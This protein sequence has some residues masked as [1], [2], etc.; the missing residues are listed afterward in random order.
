MKLPRQWTA[1]DLA[2]VAL[3][4]VLPVSMLL[5]GA[6][7]G[8]SIDPL[9]ILSG[10]GR[11]LRPG[12]LAGYPWIDPNAGTSTQALGGLS[13]SG[14]LAG[15]VP[16][17]NPYNGLGMPQAAAPL[18]A[19]FFLPFVFLLKLGNGIGAL[20][21]AMQIVAGL[22]TYALLRRL[23]L[24]WLAALVG[25][26]LFAFN[27]TFAWFA[28][29]PILP[30]AFL[31]LLLLGVERARQC[32]ADGRR[33]GWLIVAVAL[34][35]SLLAG[36][37]ETAFID[38]LLAFA[39]MV[40]R[41]WVLPA[42]PRRAFLG[43]TITGGIAGLL[44]AAPQLGPML[45][46]LA[47]NQPGLHNAIALTGL[48]AAGLASLLMPYIYGPLFG[49]GGQD[50]S[51]TLNTLW[52]EIGGYLDLASVFLAVLALAGGPRLRRLRW[53]LAAWIVAMAARTFALPG[54][55]QVLA[56]VP[57]L[58]QIAFARYGSPSV[59]MAA[60]L[61]A[62]LAIDDWQR[63]QRPRHAALLAGLVCLALALAAL[64]L[65]GR[66]IAGLHAGHAQH[67][68]SFA[69]GSVIWAASGV[70]A[71]AW[72]TLHPATPVRSLLLAAGI[73][74][75][76][77]T[78]AALPTLSGP[79]AVELD[80]APL[81]FLRAHLGL[82]RVYGMGPMAPNYGAAFGIAQIN[83]NAIPIP[84]EWID[85]IHRHLDPGEWAP[86]FLGLWPG[87]LADRQA[88][89]RDHLAGFEAAGVR[90]VMVPSGQDPL[91]A[92][93]GPVKSDTGAQPRGLAVGG[94]WSGATQPG[95]ARDG[96]VAAVRVTIGTYSGQS[97][98]PLEIEL[99]AKSG[100][101]AGRAALDTARDN[102]PIAMVL[103]SPLAVAQGE[104]LRFTL[105]RPGGSGNLAIW[106]WPSGPGGDMVPE[107]SLGYG[108]AASPVFA[109]TMADI[110]ELP[111]PAPYF[112]SACTL[113]PH[114]RTA[115]RAVCD[116]PS[117]LV[118][119]EMLYP[120]WQARVNGQPA[121]L[122][123]AAEIF[124]SVALPQG[125][126]EVEFAFVP[127]FGR[128]GWL[129]AGLGVCLSALSLRAGRVRPA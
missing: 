78:L 5:P 69:L 75:N 109:D 91:V 52:G 94:S 92:W 30:I 53:V 108:R 19:A 73:A 29:A 64:G 120:G 48:P 102:A 15:A 18:S 35:Y 110:Y 125:E 55:T 24:A 57:V 114:S 86:N 58:D 95:Q 101:V 65:G 44:L 88:A 25:G 54:L 8:A 89:L 7:L 117:V 45:E 116:R 33:G 82:Q 59:A 28:D 76:A 79:R 47:F 16:W 119:R 63:G 56:A 22:A 31:P 37:P 103:Q 83:H 9:P 121:P 100:C 32:A 113:A 81:Q 2:A 40:Q 127:T 23:Q 74:V 39:Y 90:Y 107:L 111:H 13:V 14:W 61:L 21:C 97:A 42:R 87:P 50:A 77:W 122:V 10:L 96:A 38:G 66:L 26:V 34:A 123:R 67:L 36:F 20:R 49:F 80:L 17:W 98:G 115:V 6:M 43:K 60:A 51:G 1:R 105:S 27:G 68:T 46:Y 85:Y 71:L 93:S 3:L 84:A 112:D 11:I 62:A 118:R 128:L 104:V 99:C 106:L 124:Q 72:L 41:A 126:S 4:C 12:L 70:A 129:L